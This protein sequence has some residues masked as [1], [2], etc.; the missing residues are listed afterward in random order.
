MNGYGE[1]LYQA[2][3]LFKLG[4]TTARRGP[5][6]ISLRAAASWMAV[7]DQPSCTYSQWDLVKV[8]VM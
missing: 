8:S 5:E 6:G 4:I 3:R 7:E 2:V 1:F